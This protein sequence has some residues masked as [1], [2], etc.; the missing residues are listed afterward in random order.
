MFILSFYSFL[1]GVVGI[2]IDHAKKLQRM[3]PTSIIPAIGN[4]VPSK[5]KLV[6]PPKITPIINVSVAFKDVALPLNSS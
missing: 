6:K 3:V 4:N 1:N 5:N 2:G